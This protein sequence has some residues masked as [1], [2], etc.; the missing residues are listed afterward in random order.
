MAS[1]FEA[2]AEE[3][4]SGLERDL[5]AFLRKQRWFA[6]KAREL[7]GARVVEVSGEFA[8]ST[9][10]TLV[11]V[12][13][14][15]GPPDLYSV[16]IG[17][18]EGAEA[19]R[20]AREAPARVISPGDGTRVVFDALSEPAACLTILDAIGTGATF[21]AQFG[22]IHGVPTR[23]FDQ[24]RGP[25]DRP[26]PVIRG[27]AEQSNS[28]VLFGDRLIMKIFRRLEPGTN[29]DLEI[30]RA[31]AE[32]TAFDRLPRPAGSL[33]YA[34]NDGGEPIVL[35]ILQELVK[36]EGTGWDHALHELKGYYEE[37]DRRPGI[38]PPAAPEGRS[39]L[40]LA[41]AEPP[42]EVKKLAGG[43]LQAAGVLGRRTA[44]MHRAL[45]SLEDD[46]AFAPEPI[47]A[48]DLARLSADIR[49]QVERALLALRE[50]VERLPERLREPA[51]A[52][53]T[54]ARGSSSRSIA[55]PARRSSR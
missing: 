10:L 17:T 30:G 18:A 29:P 38:E 15:D 51:T 21:P 55:C 33:E 11:E 42:A 27:S 32:K 28:A 4:G 19:A 26:L 50:H 2:K 37:I 54:G 7:T 45:A 5:P 34:P 49:E 39:A 53:L 25:V 35:A 9:R 31:L 6:G 36:N 24:A 47:S 14:R 23:T 22:S 13:Y 3:L 43:Y 46:P 41:G 1:V 52:V 16:P 20:I 44:E 40:D 12:R 8:G 48:D